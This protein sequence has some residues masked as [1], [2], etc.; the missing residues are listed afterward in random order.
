MAKID[1]A[2]M[3]VGIDFEV[4][5]SNLDAVQ[6]EFDSLAVKAK[7]PGKEIDSGLKEAAQTASKVSDILEKCFNKKLN[8]LDVSKFSQ[9]L[10]KSGLNAES[11]RNSLA[12]GGIDGANAFNKLTQEILGTNIQLKKTSTFLDKMALTFANTVRFGISSAAFNG[13]TNSLSKA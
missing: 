2:R 7:V 11:L 6:K 4:N 5:K 10:K 12:K 9:E 13:M 3:K 1:I 8:T